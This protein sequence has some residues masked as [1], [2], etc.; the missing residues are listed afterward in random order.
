[1]QLQ[2]PPISGAILIFAE[3]AELLRLRRGLESAK[4]EARAPKSLRIY[5]PTSHNSDGPKLTLLVDPAEQ[6][7]LVSL[8]REINKRRSISKKDALSYRVNP[9]SLD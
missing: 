2:L 1:M 7:E 9:Y 3:S 5:G 4:E 6:E 8:L